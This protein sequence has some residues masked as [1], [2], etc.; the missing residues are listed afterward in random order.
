MIILNEGV[1]KTE[2]DGEV[3]S[4]WCE[5]CWN[6]NYYDFANGLLA[7]TNR[8]RQGNDADWDWTRRRGRRYVGSGEDEL[9]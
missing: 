7:F 6:S 2:V 1:T 8:R 4:V 9:G 5:F 3:G